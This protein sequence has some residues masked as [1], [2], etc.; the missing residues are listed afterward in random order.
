MKQL[1]YI[2]P[3]GFTEEDDDINSFKATIEAKFPVLQGHEW[4]PLLPL[5]ARS[6]NKLEDAVL[7]RGEDGWSLRVLKRYLALLPGSYRD[8]FFQING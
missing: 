6:T 2:Q 1:N 8:V 4:K 3:I 7:P 5:G